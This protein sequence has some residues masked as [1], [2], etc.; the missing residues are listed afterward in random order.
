MT[1]KKVAFI[2]GRPAPHPA[3]A[4]IAKT[5]EADFFPVDR[6]LKYHEKTKSYRIVRYC[7][8]LINALFFPGKKKYSII[9][10]EGLHFVPIL[11]KELHLIPSSSKI[12]ALLANEV[13]WFTKSG[14]YSSFTQKMN[15]YA[16]RKYDYLVCIGEWQTILGKQLLPGKE[17]NIITIQNGVPGEKVANLAKVTPDLNSQNLLFIG[18]VQGSWRLF[19][20]GID[21]MTKAFSIAARNNDRLTFTIVGEW[22]E[23]NI[24]FAK[25]LVPDEHKEKI[26]FVGKAVNIESYFSSASLYFH[27]ANGD[28][29]PTT[30][31]EA[32]AAGLPAMISEFTGTRELVKQIS[33]ELIVPF[34]EQIIA[35]RI[36]WW[37][38]Q[39]IADKTI[40]SKKCREVASSAKEQDLLADWKIK[41]KNIENEL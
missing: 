26:I 8:W 12:V 32:M 18:N 5:V 15:M 6:F 34:D 24:A 36:E 14:K 23:S 35:E 3:H 21:V 31:L 9:I 38:R 39:S 17:T 29:Y 25:N 19:Y 1:K 13:L 2:H 27:C 28:S 4:R 33:Q 37:L 16:L 40:F 22:D 30:V 20:K 7:S 41:F 10:S 11:L